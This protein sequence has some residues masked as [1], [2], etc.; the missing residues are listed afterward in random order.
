[1][2]KK[3]PPP[4]RDYVPQ[5]SEKLLSDHLRDLGVRFSQSRRLDHDHKIDILVE[6]CGRI[7]NPPRE[8]GVQITQ[9]KSDEKKLLVF[10]NCGRN[11]TKGALLYAEVHGA[12]TEAMARGLLEVLLDI[13]GSPDKRKRDFCVRLKSSGAYERFEPDEIKKRDP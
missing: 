13:W 4:P 10:L 3:K 9:R 11:G 12:V 5:D 7:P 1:M 2:K 6:S 8:I